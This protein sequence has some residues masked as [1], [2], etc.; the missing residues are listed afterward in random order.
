MADDGT[1]GGL[2]SA[3]VIRE[4]CGTLDLG[5]QAGQA[6][7]DAIVDLAEKIVAAVGDLT[8]TLATFWIDTPS[9]DVATSSA[10]SF[11]QG[12]LTWFVLAIA[13]LSVLVAALKMAWE[14]RAQP[15]SDLARSLVQLL[16]V[17][18]AGLTGIG[19]LVTAADASA[20]WIIDRSTDDFGADLVRLLNLTDGDVAVL[21]VIVIIVVGLIALLASIVQ[22]ALLIVRNGFLVVLAGIL[23]LS[24]AAT[25]TAAG[26]QWFGKACSWL[27]AFILY[28]PAAAIVYATAFQLIGENASDDRLTTALTGLVLMILALLTL[29]ALMRFLTPLVGAAAGGGGGGAAAVGAVATGAIAMRTAKGATGAAAAG[30]GRSAG[31]GAAG[32]GGPAGAGTGGPTGPGGGRGPGGSG[33]PASPPPPTRGSAAGSAGTTAGSG[34]GGVATATRTAAATQTAARG[35]A[36]SADGGNDQTSNDTSDDGGGPSGNR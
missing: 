32:A 17:S 3:G 21:A 6:V 8:T 30:G 12:T 20:A 25:N 7:D 27:L 31:A 26:R 28:K 14:R 35:A 18:G 9:P 33:G 36:R 15:G 2:P 4:E 19:L 24:A 5:C 1:G 29:P 16:I 11:V 13:V 10:V 34:G 22:I 23:P